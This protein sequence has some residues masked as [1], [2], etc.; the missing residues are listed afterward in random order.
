[1]N[2]ALLASWS[3]VQSGSYI[4]IPT[5]HYVYLNYVAGLYDEVYLISPLSK[6]E[7]KKK[8]KIVNFPNVRIIPLPYNGSYLGAL[9]NNMAYRRALRQVCDK[10]DVIYCRVPD[11]FSWMPA[12]LFKKKTIMHFVGDTID[13]TQHNEKWGWLKKQVMIAGYLPDYWLTLKAARRSKVYTNGHHLADKLKKHRIKAIPVISSTVSEKDLHE[14]FKALPIEK[15]IV[16][17]TY[18][19]YVRFAKGMTCLMEFCKRLKNE[20]IQFHFHLVG[21]GEMFDDVKAFIERE[22]L[23]DKVTMYGYIDDK[24]KMSEI[25]RNSDLFFFPSLSEGSPRVVIEAMAQGTSVMST[26]VG[27]LPTTFE[28]GKTIRFFGFDDAEKAIEIV[29][30]YL[31]DP[32]SFEAQR[33]LAYRIVSERFTIEKFLSKVFSYEA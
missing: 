16:N 11:P 15:G 20:N 30:E 26:P 18:I 23:S 4:Y 32:V 5:T 17:I 9:K 29:K 3:L 24:A 2:I 25:L 13:A 1:M 14:D 31:A 22:V 33:Q 19:G 7:S 28:D 6:D 12:L 21:V 27:S 8:G 10:V